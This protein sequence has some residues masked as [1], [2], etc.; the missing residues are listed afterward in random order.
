MVRKPQTRLK[1]LHGSS[2]AGS[3][4]KM[5]SKTKSTEFVLPEV[6]CLGALQQC[7]PQQKESKIIF[8]TE[9]LEPGDL[10]SLERLSSSPPVAP[11]LSRMDRKFDLLATALITSVYQAR[12]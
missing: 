3:V 9:P 6:P 10:S 7:Q 11:P 1:Q 5:N 4:A 8:A 12:P 2:S